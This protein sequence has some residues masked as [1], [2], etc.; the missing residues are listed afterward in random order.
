L[1]DVAI[2]G[3]GPCGISAAIYLTR[4][5]CDVLL[6]EKDR[7]GGLLLNANLVEN[8]PGFWEGI[9]GPDLVSLFER[10]ISRLEIETQIRQVMALKVESNGFTLKTDNEEISSYSVIIASGTKPK[11]IGIVG[12]S[13]LFGRKLFYEIKDI[14]PPQREDTYMIVGAGDAAFDYALNLSDKVKR[15][16]I[17]MRGIRP[18]C[19]SLLEERARLRENIFIHPNTQPNSIEE[20][21]GKI[22]MDC[23]KEGK[24]QPILSHYGLIACGR[25]PNLDFLSSEMRKRLTIEG[26]CE[27]NSPGL[28][29]GG[30]V[31]HGHNRQTG[32]AIGDG[33]LC[34]MKVQ[35]YLAEE[36]EK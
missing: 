20:T 34:A 28:F 12:Q 14:P 10:H 9:G 19:L 13:P 23:I 32:I 4:A 35:D 17:L 22:R 11:D 25:D 36:S 29:I 30:D 2:I 3:A 1:K 7:I 6:L 31:R 15:V 21:E 18:K 16:D 27:T 8:Y 5:G 26:E 33:I 24:E